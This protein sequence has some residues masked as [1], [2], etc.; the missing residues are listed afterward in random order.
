M[1]KAFMFLLAAAILAA[2]TVQEEERTSL[3]FRLRSES[4]EI[5]YM[6][7]CVPTMLCDRLVLVSD[8]LRAT[9]EEK[10]DERFSGLDK[11]IYKGDNESFSYFNSIK[12][13]ISDAPLDVKGSRFSG[14]VESIGVYSNLDF[15]MECTETGKEWV[16]TLD[17]STVV[18]LKKNEDGV[19]ETMA[20]GDYVSNDGYD[21][22]F[23]TSVPFMYGSGGR[24]CS[25]GTLIHTVSSGSTILNTCSASFLSDGDIDFKVTSK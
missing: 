6:R 18:N 1:K 8:Y 24:I 10:D 3:Q 19:L 20:E 13:S 17:K 11:A 14:K 25:N 23:W 9:D 21:I 2:C 16:V 15:E 4:H 12:F 5:H 22:H 7:M